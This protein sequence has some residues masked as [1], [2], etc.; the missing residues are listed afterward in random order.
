MTNYFRQQALVLPYSR[1]C[2][3]CAGKMNGLL[4]PAVRLS[5]CRKGSLARLPLYRLSKS[6]RYSTTADPAAAD[7]GRP[8]DAAVLGSGPAGIA[9]V[10]KFL[11]L[12]K[13]A[14]VLWIDPEFH[15]GRVGEKYGDVSRYVPAG[16]VLLAHLYLVSQ[17][18]PNVLL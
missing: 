17:Q 15:A 3:R 8:F 18:M 2:G 1:V 7:Q 6:S 4:I 13:S 12:Q 9:T 5:S 11:D 14:R 10:G 16:N